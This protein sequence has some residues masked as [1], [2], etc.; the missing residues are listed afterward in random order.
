MRQKR[1]WSRIFSGAINAK[2]SHSA[3]SLGRLTG[4]KA[5]DAPLKGR[6]EF[7]LCGALSFSVAHR[8]T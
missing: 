7:G 8:T 4:E 3:S 5:T 1:C 2:A 6:Q